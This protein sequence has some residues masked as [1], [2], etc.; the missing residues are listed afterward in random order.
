MATGTLGTFGLWRSLVARS[1]R[2]GEVAGSNPVSPIDRLG[3]GRPS[4]TQGAARSPV[5]LAADELRPE[6]TDPDKYKVL[7]ENERVRVLE[8]RDR[9]GDKTSRT[10]TPDSVMYTLSSFERRLAHGDRERDGRLT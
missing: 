6:V 7:F 5:Q 8:H 9:P 10:V 4:A 3:E 2:V 1:V